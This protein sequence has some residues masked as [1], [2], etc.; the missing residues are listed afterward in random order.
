MMNCKA[1]VIGGVSPMTMALL[2]SCSIAEL[3]QYHPF[4]YVVRLLAVEVHANLHYWLT[5]YKE[6]LAVVLEVYLV[7]GEVGVLVYLHLNDVYLVAGIY[8]QV[9]TTLRCAHL[10]ISILAHHAEHHKQ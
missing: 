6:T 8:H 1:T 7:H 10:Y 4:C 2:S 5:L 9:S 3:I